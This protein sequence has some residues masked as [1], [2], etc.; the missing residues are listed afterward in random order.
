LPYQILSPESFGFPYPGSKYFAFVPGAAAADS[1]LTTA[2]RRQRRMKAKD[3][4]YWSFLAFSKASSIEP[5]M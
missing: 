5:T 4:A 2:R 1:R 3:A